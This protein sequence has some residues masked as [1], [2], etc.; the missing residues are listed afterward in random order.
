MLTAKGPL[1]VVAISEVFSIL[2]TPKWHQF[3]A[4]TVCMVIIGLL[5]GTEQLISASATLS[6]L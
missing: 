4:I 5:E 6:L 2:D 1:T 3:E